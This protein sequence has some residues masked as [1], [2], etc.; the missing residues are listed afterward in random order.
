VILV[1]SSLR[2]EHAVAVLQHLGNLG[3]RAELLDLA[4]FP[5]ELRLNMNYG[6]VRGWSAEFHLNGGQTLDLSDVQVV[7]WRRPQPFEVDPVIRRPSHRAFAYSESHEAVAGLWLVLDAYFV[8][9]PE[10]TEAAGRK[11]Y[12]L[13]LAQDVGLSIP[14]TLITNDPAAARAFAKA[15]DVTVYKAFSATEQEWRE[16]RLL[17]EEELANLNP[18]AYAPLIFQ[19]YVPGGVDLRVTVVGDAVY[20]AAIHAE[21]TSY[22]IDFRMDLLRARV[23]PATL[24]STVEQG[25]L[26]LMKRLDLVYGAIDMRR[27]PDGRHVF[28]EVNPAGQWLFIEQR[29]NQP[30]TAAVARLLA[31]HDHGPVRG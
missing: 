3:A 11:P 9:H 30:I 13:R 19:E 25:L 18:V 26:A 22:P 23:E 14:E 21:D 31:Q 29:T 16:T 7:W 8:N 28:L 15:H 17:R 27:T 10:A 5:K 20:A 12:Q 2:D 24:P 1:I 6:S 4:G